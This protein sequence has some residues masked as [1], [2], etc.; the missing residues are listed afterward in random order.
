LDNSLI[1]ANCEDLISNSF[2]TS[3]NNIVSQGDFIF[4]DPIGVINSNPTGFTPLG[5]ITP[6]LIE[7]Y[8][9]N[10]HAGYY[11][12]YN[13]SAFAYR[14]YSADIPEGKKQQYLLEMNLYGDLFT[15]LGNPTAMYNCHSYVWINQSLNNIFWLD[16]PTNYANHSVYAGTNCSASIGRKILIYNYQNE[17]KHS[18]VVTSSGS[19]KDNIQVVSKFGPGGL[20]SSS[21]G[22]A[23]DYYYGYSYKVYC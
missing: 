5:P 20:Y 10:Y 23:M 2:V 3:I 18:A 22:A 11:Y 4:A 13:T 17:L 9:V 16:N 6:V 8:Y 19:N 7:G 15:L 12:K 21:L 1:N 14:F